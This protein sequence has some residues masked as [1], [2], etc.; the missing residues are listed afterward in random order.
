MT[1]I[2]LHPL[3]VAEAKRLIFTA[4]EDAPLDPQ[5]VE[6]LANQA[7]GRPLFLIELLQSTASH[8]V[9]GRDP[10]IGGGDDRRPHRHPSAIRQ[11]H[12]PQTGGL[13]SGFSIEHTSAV[14]AEHEANARAQTPLR[15]LSEFCQSTT[16][17]GSTSSTP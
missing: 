1:R 8:R 14:I 15:R 13:G 4:T 17:D 6:R 5:L 7:N 2:D 10:A 9:A 11:D 16:P 3:G 12:P